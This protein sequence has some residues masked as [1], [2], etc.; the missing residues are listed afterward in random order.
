MH[1]FCFRHDFG[2]G[3]SIDCMLFCSLIMSL[4]NNFKALPFKSYSSDLKRKITRKKHDIDIA[5]NDY[6]PA[7]GHVCC[8]IAPDS[9]IYFGGARRTEEATWSSNSDIFRINFE[10]EEDDISIDTIT[11]LKTTGGT[12][13]S[14]QGSSAVFANNNIYVWGGLDLNNF[15]NT[16]ELYILNS[17]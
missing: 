2:V 3:C 12:F 7:E 6:F 4:Y 16:N 1:A 14:L 11:K 8:Q 5:N 15:K 9:A 10:I 13:P 17:L